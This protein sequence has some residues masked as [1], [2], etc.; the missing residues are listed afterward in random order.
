M[1][2]KQYSIN[3]VLL[4]LGESWSGLAVKRSEQLLRLIRRLSLSLRFWLV[5]GE[6]LV[7]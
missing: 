5:G 1:K 4:F 3:V 2:G 6:K 7:G